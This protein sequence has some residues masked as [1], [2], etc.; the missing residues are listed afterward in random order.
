[1]VSALAGG[2]N[3]VEVKAMGCGAKRGTNDSEMYLEKPR[4]EAVKER[5]VDMARLAVSR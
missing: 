4:L 1:M 2:A 3:G 5:N